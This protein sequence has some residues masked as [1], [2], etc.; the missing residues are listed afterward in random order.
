MDQ[1]LFSLSLMVAAAEISGS[2]M[3]ECACHTGGAVM[4]SATARMDQMRWSVAEDFECTDG[5]GCVIES[6]VCDGLAQCPDGSD[7]WDCSWRIGCQSDD[8]KCRNNIC[9][10][11]ELL[12]N[13][14]DD[15]G[16]NSDEEACG[17]CE[18]MGI[19]CPDGACLSQREKCDGV[20]Q[21]SDQR[22][23]PLTCGKSCRDGN[24]GCSHNCSE[25]W[26]GA[27]CS[28]PAGMS[29]SANGQACEDVNECAQPF[30]PCIQ[31]CS[32][33]PGS[34]R[35]LCQN[36]FKMLS[37]DSC[38]APGPEVK[39]LTI[40]NGLVGLVNVRTRLYEPVFTSET[41]LVAM[42]SDVQ[43]NVIYWAG[44][45]GNI[46]KASNRKSTV[47]YSG[48]EGVHSLAVDWITGQLYWTSVTQKAIL[49]GASDGSVMGVILSKHI[50]PS[51]LV[52]S[53]IESFL[54]WMNKGENEEMTIERADMDGLARTTLVFITAQ[55]PKSLTLDVT[56]SRLYWI[57]VLKMSIETIRTDGT[58][59]FT[60][61][62]VFDRSPPQALAVFNGWFFW[63]DQKRLW[64]APQVQATDIQNGFI[65]KAT[66][67]LLSIYHP[68]QQP[69]GYSACKNSG[70]QLC[71]PSKMSNTGFTCLC[72]E[73]TLPMSYG[74]CENFKV[75]YATSMAIYSLEFSGRTPVKT[76]LLKTEEDIQSF[77]MY[78]Q[79]ECVVWSNGT[80]HVKTNI[81]DKD[82]SE[83]ILTM[84]PACIVRVD[85]R[86]GNLYWLACDELSIGVST[87]GPLERS[88]SR[89]LYQAKSP[90]QDLFVDWQ[91][92]K[93]YW[94]EG[95][96]IMRMKLG[97]FGGNAEAVFSF[98]EYAVMSLLKMRRY[99]AGKDKIIPGFIMAAYEPYMVAL[100]NDVL[101]VWNRKN[102]ARV[103]GVVVENEIVGMSVAVREIPQG[104]V[105]EVVR[106]TEVT[107]KSPL[108]LCQGSTVCISRSQQ[109]DG[110]RD[111][112]DGSDEA[113][114]LH[115]CAKPDDFLCKDGSKC[116]EKDVLCDGVFDCFD[117]SDEGQCSSMVTESSIMGPLR[118]RLGSKPCENGKKCVLLS[119]L[120]DGEMDCD[121]ESDEQDCD[122]QCEPGDFL[123]GDRSKCID[124]GLVC[125]GRSDCIDGSDEDGCPTISTET[126]V[127]GP[128]RCRVG[129]TPCKNG[130]QCVLNT[131]LCDN[132]RDC[133]DGSDEHGCQTQCE[134][135]QFQCA[136]GRMCIDRK[137][138]CDGTAQCQDRSDEL[139]CFTRS[140]DCKHQCDNKTRCIPESFL[141]DGERDCLDATDEANCSEIKKVEI[142]VVSAKKDSQDFQPP[143]PVCRSPSMLC[144]GTSICIPQTRLCNGKLDC[145]D[146]SDEV[147]CLDAC[148]NPGEFLCKDR[149]K[150]V[151]EDLVCDG[152][153]DCFDG[154]DERDCYA[155]GRVSDRG[156]LKC[157]VGSKAC[158]NGQS[159]V[160]FINLCD[161]ERDCNDG[162]DEWGCAYRC[163]ADQFQCAHGRMC[164]DRKLVCD[165]TAQCQD[166]S[167]ELN[168]FTRSHDCKHQCDNKTRCIPESFLSLI[169]ET[170]FKGPICS[171][172]SVFCHE[173]SKCISGS[174]LC[175]GKPDCPNGADELF[176]LTSCPDPGQFLCKD[177]RSCLHKDLVCD[178]YIQCADGSDEQ[179]CPTC[180]LRCDQK[181]V[182]L[183]KP[184][185][186]DGTQDCSDG[187][188]E[189]NCYG[190]DASA[191]VPRRC[192]LSS[193]PCRN[194][195]E[196]VPNSNVC[197][198][199][200]DC[201]DG[202]DEWGCEWKCRKDQFQC[203]HGKKCID[204]NQVCDGTAQ[205]QDRSDEMK[206]VKVSDECRHPCDNYTRC[207]P[208]T[209]L[210]DGER[211]FVE[212]C[213]S[214]GFQ[215]SSG[216]CVTLN[217]RCDGYADCRDHS[218]EKGCPQPPHCPVNLRCPHTHQCLLN[219]WFCD[220]E[221]DCSDGFDE[222]NCEVPQLKC[223]AFQWPCASKTQ[224]IA[225]TW[226]CDGMKDCK[227]E[228]DEAGCGEVK[229]P[230]HLYRCG[231]GE[232]VEPHLFCNEVVDCMDA[233][234]EEQLSTFAELTQSFCLQRCGCKAGF[235]LQPDGL[236]CMDI[237]ECK[238]IQTAPCSQNCINT[239][240]SY[241]CRC[242]PDFILEPDGHSC[243]TA[244]E[245]RLL[246]SEQDE[247]VCLSLRSSR[248]QTLAEPGRKPI[249]SLDYDLRE[250][251]VYWVS[252]E[253]KSIKY[254]SHDEKENTGTIVKG[255]KSDSIAIDWLGR[256]LY[257]VDG[258][259][260]Q[261]LAVRLSSSVVQPEDFV[262]VLE[263]DLDQVNSLVLLPQNGIMVWSKIGGEARIER[264]SMDGADRKVLISRGLKWPVSLS[265]DI[266]TDR[267]YWIDEKLS[268]V[269]SASL[270]GEN[271]RFLQLTEMPSP[272]SLAVF[273]DQIY[274][275]DAQRRSVQAADKVTGKNRKT[276]LKRP[277]QPFSLKVAHHLLQ[278][279]VSNPCEKLRCSHVCLLAPGLR[280]LCRCP[281]GVLLAADGVTCG[282]P[283]DTSSSFLMLLSRTTIT[284][285]FLGSE[286]GLKKWPSHRSLHLLGV[287]EASGFDLLLR[288]SSL[289]VADASQGSVSQ[290]KLGSSSLTPVGPL[291]QLK[292]DL[293]TALAV[294][295]VTQN[296]FWSSVQSPQIHVTAP[297][298]KYSRLVLQVQLEG[299][300][301]IA[302]HPPS[303][304]LCFTAV[305]RRGPES[306]PQ[307]D[308]A[309]MDGNN[310]TLLWRGSR[311]AVSL[312]FSGT[313]K[314]LYWAD[315]KSRL[316]CSINMDGSK[317]MEYPTGSD[318]MVSFARIDNIFFWVTLENGTA[319]LWF[320]DSF[321]PKR[322]WFEVKTSAVELKAYSSSSQKGT[323]LCSE[324]NGGCSHFCLPYPGGRSCLCAQ[325]YLTVNTTKCVSSL[326]CPLG[327]RACGDGITCIAAAKFCD[328]VLDCP[329]G[330]DEECDFGKTK[331]G[332][333]S[334][335]GTFSLD[336]T[337]DRSPAQSCDAELCSGHGKCAIVKA[338]PV[339][340]CDE[341]FSGDLC[342][343]AKSSHTALALTLT[344]LFGGA[345][346]AALILR[347]RR[348]QAAREKPI[349]KE[350]LVT[351]VE[352]PITFSTQNFDNELYDPEEASIAPANSIPV[353]S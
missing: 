69:Q 290:L 146:G 270:N 197:D 163:K 76:D 79:R 35:C 161:G 154:S 353:S 232:C 40:R 244:D 230:T 155:S 271:I 316:I 3:M 307:I 250:G 57:S 317:Y 343:N 105:A 37:N 332:V 315:I 259:A 202:S 159:C 117:G 293:L 11:R 131:H 236:T 62:D 97:L 188:D 50:D 36:G 237:D 49:T 310:R 96:Q 226:R 295:W 260:G 262:V 212:P 344:F 9:I 288:D 63:A 6:G 102:G 67:P 320:S 298:G 55:L 51:D 60:F 91:R 243:K 248:I 153:S 18:K 207:V 107:C 328:Q 65:L 66:L 103:S 172:P 111:C 89:Q 206:C 26:W 329:D 189:K 192:P 177:R 194:G 272:L 71:L 130:L 199:E 143:A 170:S 101:T 118:C 276:L 302:L 350:N 157:R 339:C 231:S 108:V 351:D 141:C 100:F 168:C 190:V 114:C 98:E 240:G 84:K 31:L 25:Q 299:M 338:V 297:G 46:Y 209:F 334:K 133:D 38:E 261:I 218:D 73:G 342:Q 311:M 296:L 203:A 280:A 80:G 278:P 251:R 283:V 173:T 137:L 348:S 132:E 349:E 285:I 94:L 110:R 120:C 27:L 152:R 275:S 331:P 164:I 104:K 149:R 10:P 300:V 42:S 245:P 124:G 39:L 187:S 166:R 109:C 287:S 106:R 2:V 219:E 48:Q 181:T 81:R 255:V 87:V 313:G 75:A 44:V 28:C 228:S 330:S 185:L 138:V 238:E 15:C 125:D 16:D 257:W 186:C 113:S 182:C 99:S 156:P 4:A 169:T 239:L 322:L 233:S 305:G 1:Y 249:F 319:K 286:L 140:H 306:L 327:N 308:C 256:N 41:E 292:G 340:E 32:N 115:M 274:W 8:W 282:P 20:S 222:R 158:N 123:C 224:C 30:G 95:N 227:D 29:L 303:G 45:N 269:V 252:F 318:F 213:S 128:L 352:E 242:H 265:V 165:G 345:L 162:S 268:C 325:N 12:C 148:S 23:E 253:D 176:C 273:N 21:C 77:D 83:Y 254:V 135:D 112:P 267:L 193:K 235:R 324:N 151:E 326:Q 210:C 86:T 52:I 198:G 279:N 145:P 82:L 200:K 281:P 196:C 61:W 121:D 24:G 174:Q 264:S 321:Q 74:A 178:G 54:F 116:V 126:T 179:R 85:Q 341:G 221:Q 180:A 134:A 122:E 304:R 223:G 19:R 136:H 291:L 220:G 7:E 17:A 333:K 58:G 93:L 119:H 88:I 337:A 167:D 336:S 127:S 184:Q 204:L 70:C 247:L 208:E 147:S 266:L 246:V 277:G 312:A 47:I 53:S 323:N 144:P 294:D 241:M 201:T 314:A 90:I 258:V 263:E 183:T 34:Y 78:W 64:Q 5:S 347:R 56:A 301:S 160:L 68:L 72:P 195:K 217:L 289:S 43:R 22:D 216:Q 284:Q 234:D 225:K 14:E 191:S 309:H 335:S 59:R 129:S 142:N 171:S 346:V 205:C 150:C 33:T 139:N 215:C 175:D 214:G 92:G 13:E 211:D 229:C